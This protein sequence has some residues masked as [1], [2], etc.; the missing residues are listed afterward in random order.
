M[1][2]RL[3]QDDRKTAGRNPRAG[4]ADDAAADA[5]KAAGEQRVGDDFLQPPAARD[6]EQ[7]LLALAPG[8]FDEIVIAETGGFLQ[9]RGGDADLV[10]SRKVTSRRSQPRFHRQSIARREALLIQS[11]WVL[12]LSQSDSLQDGPERFVNHRAPR[13]TTDRSTRRPGAA[14]A[15]AQVP[16]RP[17]VPAP[18]SAKS[19]RRSRA[20]ADAGAAR[21][22]A[23]RCRRCYRRRSASPWRKRARAADGCGR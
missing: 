14:H 12:V 7:M 8:D 16:A 23:G 15:Y 20:N 1:I 3:R 6:R 21:R 18:C 10:V 22:I 5:R 4:I 2:F 11:C 9:D 13:E 17:R 19:A